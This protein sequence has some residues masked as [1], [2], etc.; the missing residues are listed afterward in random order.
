MLIGKEAFEMVEFGERLRLLRQSAHLT[1]KLLAEKLGLTSSVVSA[2]ETGVRL[3]SYDV[4]IH[5]ARIFHV[6]VD[7]LLGIQEQP[8]VDLSHLSESDRRLVMELIQR[9]R[10]E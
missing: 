5:I 10:K 8:S 9:L 3:P 2:Y 7:F 4:L 1:Q 6:S